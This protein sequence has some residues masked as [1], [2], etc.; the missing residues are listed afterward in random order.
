VKTRQ[1]EHDPDVRELA[2]NAG[3]A[4]IV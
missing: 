4:R 2:I 1:S 3:G